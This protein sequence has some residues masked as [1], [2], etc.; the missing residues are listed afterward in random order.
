[1]RKFLRHTEKSI[2]TGRIDTESPG[3]YIHE[4]VVCRSRGTYDIAEVSSKQ[5]LAFLGYA[6]DEGVRRN[7]GRVGADSGPIHIRQALA[8]LPAHFSNETVLYDFG[9]IVSSETDLEGAQEA[10]SSTLYKLKNA[11]YFTISFGGG[12]DIAYPHFKAIE[13][14]NENKIIGIINLDAHFDLR[15][16]HEGSNSG[17]PFYQI[18]ED[19]KAKGTAF[20]YLCLGIQKSGNTKLLF[21]TADEYG[22]E[23]IPAEKFTLNNEKEITKAVTKFMEK[24]DVIYL[25]IDMD[26]F[27]SALSPG[28]SAPTSN[29]F[30]ADEALLVLKLAINSKKLTSIDF[31]ETNPTFDVDDR[32]S[33]L[34]SYLIFKL[35]ELMY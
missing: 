14:S 33:K 13:K 31:A 35:F 32:T 34:V 16:P 5:A 9:N 8:K 1:M 23:Y 6:I 3:N 2:W 7:G 10:F 21:E 29:G 24:C 22:V 17:T 28:V 27:S 26:G 30:A 15:R 11:G 19:C 20:N 4:H 25:T 12:H 18:A